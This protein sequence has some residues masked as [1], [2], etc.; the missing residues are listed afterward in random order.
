MSKESKYLLV[1]SFDKLDYAE[2]FLNGRIRMM[3]LDYYRQMEDDGHGRKDRME[4]VQLH[5]LGEYL[6]LDID[7]VSF[8][9]AGNVKVITMGTDDYAQNTKIS[10]CTLLPLYESGFSWKECLR[11]VDLPYCVLFSN[12][13]AFIER[14]QYAAATMEPKHGRVSYF[15]PESWNGNVNCFMKA[16]CFEKQSEY[17]LTLQS[18][19]K[20]PYILD[21]GSL[22]DIAQVFLTKDLIS[23]LEQALND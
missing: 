9:G 18:T 1:R 4:G 8:P 7:G 14:F 20:D 6:T 22:R 5:W 3:S 2:D 23:K 13:D 11:S 19:K 12:P 10:C 21:I 16:K 15:Y 17:R